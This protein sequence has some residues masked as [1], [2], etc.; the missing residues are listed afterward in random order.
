MDAQILIITGS[1]PCVIDD[2][3]DKIIFDIPNPDFM[4]IGLD[5]VD[6]YKRPI[7]YVVTYHEEEIPAIRERRKSFGGNTDY[8]VVTH[9]KHAG[10]DIIIADYWM[11]SGSSALLGVQA[12]LR[13]GYGKIILCGCPLDGKN[14]AGASYESFRAGWTA[15]KNELGDNVRSMRGWTKEFLSAPT[16]E[17]LNA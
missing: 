6:K 4:A 5:A 2:L 16:Q 7:K 9:L 10:A 17:W 13:L 1:A 11:P 15:R 3:T 12:A 14:L 8:Q